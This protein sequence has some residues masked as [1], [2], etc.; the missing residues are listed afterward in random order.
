ML[1]LKC[2]CGASHDVPE[3]FVGENALCLRCGDVLYA[4]A[5]GAIASTGVAAV[6][7][8][9]TV[10]AGPERVG[11]QFFPVGNRPVEI[12][13]LPDKVICLSGSKVPRNHCQLV[14]SDA[15]WRL[16]DQ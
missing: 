8:R 12:G 9:L 11:Q 5:G 6:R 7:A 16:D 1:S 13:K 10:V 15:G 4:V 3:S 2:A 14:R